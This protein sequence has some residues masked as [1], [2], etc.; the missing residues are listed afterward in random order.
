MDDKQSFSSNKQ[1]LNP[2]LKQLYEKIMNTP[3]KPLSSVPPLQKAQSTASPPQYQQPHESLPHLENPQQPTIQTNPKPLPSQGVIS[4]PKIQAKSTLDKPFVFSGNK[5]LPQSSASNQFVPP[6]SAT[7]VV[8]RSGSHKK[9]FAFLAIIFFVG[10]LFF[11]LVFFNFISL[12]E[13]ALS[14][15][16]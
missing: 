6:A 11:W 2:E 4:L 8:P 7:I 15:F 3:V 1:S 14:S 16:F 12:S 10:Y 5:P 13:V 9:L